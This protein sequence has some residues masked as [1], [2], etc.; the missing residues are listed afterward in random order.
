VA[1]IQ[2]NWLVDEPSAL[3]ANSYPADNDMVGGIESM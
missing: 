1:R 2:W 3:T